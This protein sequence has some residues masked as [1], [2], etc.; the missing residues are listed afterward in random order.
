MRSTALPAEL[1]ARPRDSMRTRGRRALGISATPAAFIFFEPCKR[2]APDPF[3]R[4]AFRMEVAKLRLFP[5]GERNAHT[6]SL[7]DRQF[8]RFKFHFGSDIGHCLN[9]PGSP[10]LGW[11]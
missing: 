5:L 2:P 8:D 6:P 10:N 3:L 11:A 4:F 7:S 1:G 9:R